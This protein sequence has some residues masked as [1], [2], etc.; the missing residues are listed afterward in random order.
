VCCNRKAPYTITVKEAYN[1]YSKL[2]SNYGTR[3]KAAKTNEGVDWKA[4]SHA[5]RVARQAIELAS[6]G[7]IVFPLT[8]AEHL[9]RIKTGQIDFEKVG[10]EIEDLLGQVESAFEH[11][12]LPTKPDRE[13]VDDFIYQIYSKEIT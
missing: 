9:V 8:Y 6:T 5:V 13:W 7:E 1:I 4:C 3:A 11:S 10:K 2:Y 12:T